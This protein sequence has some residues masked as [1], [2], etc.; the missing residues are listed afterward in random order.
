MK[1]A[2]FVR[3]VESRAD[4]DQRLYKLS[5]PLDGNEYV[6]VS[7]TNVMFSGRETYIF[8]SNE[9]GE[10]VDW[11]ELDGSFSGEIDHAQA[12]ENAGYEVRDE[13]PR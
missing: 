9:A 11:L 6:I 10:I 13:L 12:L 8:P 4:V 7:G 3:K 1:T 2:T 5:D